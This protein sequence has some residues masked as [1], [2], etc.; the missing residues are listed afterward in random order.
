MAANNTFT[1]NIANSNYNSFQATVERKAADM[2]FLA[3]YTF[4]KAMDDSSGFGDLMNFT[5]YA[6]QPRAVALRHDAQFRRQLQLGGA[7]RPGFQR[8]CQ[9]A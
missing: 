5:N 7:V 1:A 6:A 2:T 8:R 4:S 3:A 9:S